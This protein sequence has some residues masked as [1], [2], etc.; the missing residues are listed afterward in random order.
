MLEGPPTTLAARVFLRLGS[1]LGLYAPGDQWYWRGDFFDE[2]DDEAIVRNREWNDR[3]P[4]WKSGS[5]LYPVDGT[6]QDVAV[7][8]TAYAYRDA[9]WSQVI[10]A[11][12][13]DPAGAG[14]IRDWATGYWEA[15]HPYS[16]GGAYV[17]F[18][19]DEGQARVRATYGQNY[20]RLAR[21]KT[22]ANVSR[23]LRP[24][25]PVTSDNSG[26]SKSADVRDFVARSTEAYFLDLQV[27]MKGSPGRVRAS[28]S[29]TAPALAGGLPRRIRITDNSPPR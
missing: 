15:L 4:T 14:A 10:I 3:T 20:E 7:D 29:H 2:I 24:E 11:V 13:P 21:V 8:D 12:D 23:A 22:A 28:A 26:A 17:N 9:T 18:M 19:M 6:A 16:A 27:V 1:H 5:H 25:L